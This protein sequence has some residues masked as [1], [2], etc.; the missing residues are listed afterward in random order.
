MNVLDYTSQISK[1]Q[2][3]F[4]AFSSSFYVFLKKPKHFE[5]SLLL[6][7]TFHF[8]CFISNDCMIYWNWISMNLKLWFQS[9]WITCSWKMITNNS[10]RTNNLRKIWKKLIEYKKSKKLNA[11]QFLYV[12]TIHVKFRISVA[13]KLPSISPCFHWRFH[14]ITGR[15]SD[16]LIQQTFRFPGTKWIILNGKLEK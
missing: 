10:K 2:T 9:V 8:E 15:A 14:S 7:I 13:W 16:R 6:K 5:H 12:R 1:Y 11:E 3:E 4:S